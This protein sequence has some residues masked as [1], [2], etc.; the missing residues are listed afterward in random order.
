MNYKLASPFLNRMRFVLDRD[1]RMTNV[2][3]RVLAAY[4]D[5]PAFTTDQAL[6]YLGVKGST[7]TYRDIHS[8]VGRLAT[9]LRRAGI[10][11]FERVAIYKRNSLDYF[12]VSLAIMRAGAIAVPV[13][14]R[15][16]PQNFKAY[17]EYTGCTMVY[18]DEET[19]AK[20]GP[21]SMPN[22]RTWILPSL[23]AGTLLSNSIVL[24]RALTPD[25]PI[26]DP[27]RINRLDDVLI[28]HTSGTTGFPKGVL[29]SSG[30]LVHSVRL[31]LIRNPIPFPDRALMAAHQN[32]HITFTCML[33]SCVTGVWSYVA[34]DHSPK[35]VLEMLQKHK[36][37]VFFAF[38]DIY[39]A[40]CQTGLKDAALPSM[41]IWLTGG[42][43]MHEAHIRQCVEK[44]ENLK[45]LGLSLKGSIFMELLGTSEVGSAA[46][47]K[48]STVRTKRYGRYVGKPTWIGMKVKV[49]NEYGEPVPVGTAG[50]LMVHGQTLFKGYWNA[51]DRLH[52]V[53]VDGWWWTGDIARQDSKGRIYHLDR[54][55]DLVRTSRGPVFGLPIEEE[56]LKCHDIG[57][58]AVIGLTHPQDGTVPVAVVHSL[59]GQPV[60]TTTVLEQVNRV[61]PVDQRLRALIDVDN[62]SGVPRG[63]TGKVLKRELRERFANH[64]ASETATF[65]PAL[66]AFEP[67]SHARASTVT[68]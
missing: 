22:V 15:L 48:M 36:I 35:H 42:D 40:L 33:M 8:I 46:L 21:E 7:L 2:T 67:S 27:V 60:D 58:A 14:G 59:S 29:H 56:L 4:G 11:R 37:T 24:V 47:I 20:L 9:L 64:F 25:V 19:V 10:S 51:H 68:A 39:L 44:G 45:I 57:E 3:E 1:L 31:A 49:A 17:V 54:E 18:T 62:A 26:A 61:L 6:D 43:A 5:A 16:S 13:H 63:L 30:S 66:R 53:I 38:P 65:N 12:L 34:T 23:S 32:H 28:A 41:R 52:H 50:R 55:V